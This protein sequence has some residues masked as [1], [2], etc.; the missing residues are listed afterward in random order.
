MSDNKI[1]LL[2][3]GFVNWTL[4]KPKR[5]G[6]IVYDKE[7]FYMGV[8]YPSNELTDFGGEINYVNED[9]IVGSIREYNEETLGS[10]PKLNWYEV[11]S[12]YA[13]ISD[14]IVIF[15]FK[16]E[17]PLDKFIEKFKE[18]IKLVKS[19]EISN[20]LYIKREDIVKFPIYAKIKPMI[21]HILDKT[22]LY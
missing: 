21:L 17:S 8:D 10:F 20:I 2:K 3:A 7:G 1:L 12:S 15:L 16:T 11:F 19:F 14:S 9:T 5:A 4:S 13:V 18:N 6:I 22:E